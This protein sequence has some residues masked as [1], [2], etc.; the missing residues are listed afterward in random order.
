MK[1]KRDALSD[2][3]IARNLEWLETNGIGGYASGTVAGVQSRR[4]HGLLIAAANPP[5]GRMVILSKLDET[6]VAGENR[7]QLGTNQYPG[8][9]HPTGFRF[10]R[11]FERDLFPVFYFEAGGVIVKKTI[12]AIH[13]ENTTIVL[14]EVVDAIEPFSFELLPLYSCRD[15]HA[16]ARANDFIG[17]PYVFYD[18]IFRT[19]NYHGCP[20]LFISVPGAAFVESKGWYYNLEYAVEQHRG[21]EFREDLYTHGKFCLTLSKSDKFGVIISIDEP[22]GR[23]AFELFEIERQRRE[24]LTKKFSWNREL[25]RLSLAADQFIVKRGKHNTIIAG[26][27]WFADWGRDTMISLPGLCLVTGRFNE[28]KQILEEFS[29]CIDEGMLPNRFPDHGEPPEYN[30]ID[31]TLW[32]FNAIYHYYTYTRDKEFISGLLPVLKD[33]IAWHYQGT[34]YNIKVDPQDE[35]LS[36][37]AE[38]VQLTW[39]DAK[40][41]N[42]VV[43]PRKGKVVEINALWYNALSIMAMLLKE[44]Q[45]TEE[46]DFYKAKAKRVHASFNAVFWNENKDSLYDYIDGDDKCEDIRPNQIFAI[47]LPFKVLVKDRAKRVIDTVTRHLL[48]PRG[49]RTLSA[50][51][52]DFKRNYAGGIWNRDGAYHQGTVWSF[53]IGPYIDAML[54]I[55]R[56]NKSQATEILKSFFHHLNEAGVG[57]VSEIFDAEFPYTSRGCIAQAW[58]VAELL[59]VAVEHKLIVP[60]KIA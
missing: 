37:G 2:F 10:L 58:G 27:H 3:E 55:N 16:L 47:S 21:M 24:L 41:G 59:R 13:G 46:S 38:G 45:N 52:K 49:L 56:E 32:F 26:Y 14:Y 23:D 7:Y 17:Q 44:F 36:G 18:G 4:Y 20:E 5:V 50:D 35:L 1:F 19:L 30:T 15:F 39:M 6:I 51:H 42:W 48:T 29:L 33:I 31:A 34:R 54:Y 40:V 53:L 57:T 22:E 11:E 43:T 60:E 28:A 9:L 8:A 12:A 25:T